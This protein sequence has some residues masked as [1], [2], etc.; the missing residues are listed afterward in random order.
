MKLANKGTKI[1]ARALNEYA[2]LSGTFLN[3]Q[4]HR[5]VVKTYNSKAIIR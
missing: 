2:R 1:N 5:K 4:I 3:I